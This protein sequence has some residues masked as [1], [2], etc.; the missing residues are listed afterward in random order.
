MFSD[1]TSFNQPLGMWNV[2]KVEDMKYMFSHDN[3]S[4]ANYDQLLNDWS[5]LPLQHSISFDGG[6]SKYNFTATTARNKLIYIFNWT[7]NDGGLVNL[8]VSN[9]IP[10]IVTV[11]SSITY[12]Y[13]TTGHIVSIEVSDQHP[14]MYVV[15]EN[16]TQYDA[17]IW[18]SGTNISLSVDGLGIGVYNFSIYV[19][20]TFNNQAEATIIVTVLA[21]ISSSVIPF[22]SSSVYELIFSIL[23]MGFLAFIIGCSAIGLQLHTYMSIKKK[24]RNE[25]K[26]TFFSFLKYRYSKLFRKSKPKQISDETFKLLEELIAENKT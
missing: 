11:I 16:G 15:Y 8:P 24:M 2:S 3:L 20:D 4:I 7:I 6:L 26:L 9:K 21:P 5:K 19:F 10:P 23:T 13:G 12:E 17:A 14:S 25:N 1:A 22:L 18:T